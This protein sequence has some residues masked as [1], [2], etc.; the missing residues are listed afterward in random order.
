ME[1]VQRAEKSES[2]TQVDWLAEAKKCKT[3]DELRFLWSKAR[4]VNADAEV[5]MK[6]QEM[7]DAV[8]NT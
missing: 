7:A 8:S 3:K 5:L 1:K 2:E 6:I 4:S